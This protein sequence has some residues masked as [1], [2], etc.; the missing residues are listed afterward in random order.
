MWLGVFIKIPLNKVALSST[1]YRCLVGVN[2]QSISLQVN[3]LVYE[4]LREHVF[5]SPFKTNPFWHS[6]W[7]ESS[8]LIQ[9]CSQSCP[10]SHWSKPATSH[11]EGRILCCYRNLRISVF[12]TWCTPYTQISHNINIDYQLN[13]GKP[14]KDYWHTRLIYVWLDQRPAY[15]VWS[16]KKANAG[17]TAK[18]VSAC[19]DRKVPEY[20]VYHTSD[21]PSKLS[22]SNQSMGCAR[23]ISPIHRGPTP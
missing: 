23:Q 4:V 13:T 15:L 9:L 22:I 14:V 20:P 7:Y 10:I 1:R 8:L 17:K 5:L 21:P 12:K 16:T 2:I 6:Q 18:N 11:E 19:H 3:S